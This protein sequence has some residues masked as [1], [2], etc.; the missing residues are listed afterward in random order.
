M[1][2]YF[3]GFFLF[4]FSNFLAAGM[5]GQSLP[6]NFSPSSSSKNQY[7]LLKEHRESLKDSFALQ[8][9]AISQQ[10][11][12]LFALEKKELEMLRLNEEFTLERKRAQYSAILLSLVAA[13]LLLTLY[14]YRQRKEKNKVLQQI[15]LTLQSPAPALPSPEAQALQNENLPD[16]KIQGLFH[17]IEEILQS[18]KL[19]TD[20]TLSL[21]SLADMLQSNPNYVSRAVN[22]MTRKNF[23]QYINEE[24]IKEAQR[25]IY[26]RKSEA[27][28]PEIWE[29]CGFVSRSTFYNAFQKFSGMTPIEFKK[30]SLL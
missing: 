25:L 29:E 19:Y 21:S 18:Q 30:K 9:E 14:F 26:M 23:N 22:L 5:E 11:E 3:H 13:L 12:E 2:P 1:K 10:V 17:Q 15:D 20:P 24:R 28:L 6:T 27:H 16:P 4:L 7:L 8:R